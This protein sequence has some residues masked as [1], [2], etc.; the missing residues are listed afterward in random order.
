MSSQ[1]TLII[2]DS[3]FTRAKQLTQVR[4]EKSAD[5]LVDLL[6]QILASVERSEAEIDEEEAW[7][8]EDPA[9]EREMQAYI[10]MHPVLK[11]TH[12][13]KHVAIYE[14]RLIDADD[15]Y[16]TLTRR[17]DAQYPDQF[18]WVSTVDEEPIKT[19][20]FRSPRLE[21]LEQVG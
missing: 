3:L 6:D 8:E 2:P 20:V 17:I 12:F 18:V 1:V 11:K 13:G 9:V 5:E 7:V 4:K 15:D 14:G 10:A 16:D 19:F 21:Q